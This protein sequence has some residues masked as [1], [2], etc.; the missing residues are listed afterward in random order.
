MRFPEAAWDKAVARLLYDPTVGVMPD[1]QPE[2]DA[3]PLT[4]TSSLTPAG[5]ASSAFAVSGTNMLSPKTASAALSTAAVAL[6]GTPRIVS[7]T[8]RNQAGTSRR[9]ARKLHPYAG[10]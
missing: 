5:A 1:G 10:E 9:R 8:I 4:E 2:S 6:R 3:N 7:L